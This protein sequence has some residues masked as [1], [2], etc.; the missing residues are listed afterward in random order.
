MRWGNHFFMGVD[1]GWS[2]PGLRAEPKRPSEESNSSH[3]SCFQQVEGSWLRGDVCSLLYRMPELITL[4]EAA[5]SVLWGKH[6][7]NSGASALWCVAFVWNAYT[8]DQLKDGTNKPEGSGAPLVLPISLTNSDLWAVGRKSSFLYCPFMLD[9]LGEDLEWNPCSSWWP[10]PEVSGLEV[11]LYESRL[12]P[13][14]WGRPWA[15]IE[16]VWNSEW[17]CLCRTFKTSLFPWKWNTMYFIGREH[18]LVIPKDHGSVSGQMAGI[19]T[20]SFI[21]LTA[22]F[23]VNKVETMLGSLVVLQSLSYAALCDLVDSS[24]PGSSVSS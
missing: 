17:K 10:L 21:S 11:A 16:L 3:E 24:R 1:C 12:P 23:F 5:G 20:R 22:D 19:F 14:L 18:E 6:R 9:T 8:L 2:I 15:K 13:T 7:E 4:S